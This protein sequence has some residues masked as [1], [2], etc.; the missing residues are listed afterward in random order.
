MI[1]KLN[2][3]IYFNECSNHSLFEPKPPPYPCQ[4]GGVIICPDCIHHE[5]CLTDG[6]KIDKY[7]IGRRV[8]FWDGMEHI[9]GKIMKSKVSDYYVIELERPEREH[10]STIIEAKKTISPYDLTAL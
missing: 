6:K 3:K 1:N 4:S 5:K 7:K 2:D 10:N 9:P 8:L